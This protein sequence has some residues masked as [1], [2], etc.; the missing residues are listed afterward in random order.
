MWG[1]LRTSLACAG[2]GDLL[3]AAD[4]EKALALWAMLPGR[5]NYG[6]AIGWWER[7]LAQLQ[8]QA[9]PCDAAADVRCDR[10]RSPQA[11]VAPEE[12]SMA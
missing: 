6:T 2:R 12:G 7:E 5:E 3:E 1:Y 8:A 10:L 9:G 11:G 4:G